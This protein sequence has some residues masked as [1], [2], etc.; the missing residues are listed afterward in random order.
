MVEQMLIYEQL[1][2]GTLAQ[3]WA[4]GFDSD[5]RVRNWAIGVCTTSNRT[6]VIVDYGCGEKDYQGMFE[7]SGNT[8]AE[9]PGAFFTSG[10]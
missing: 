7:L 10:S 1:E 8:N 5:A 2:I 3:S 4:Q 6:M 9:R